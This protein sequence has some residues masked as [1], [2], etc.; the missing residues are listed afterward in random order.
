MLTLILYV[1]VEISTPELARFVRM[2]RDAGYRF[3][4]L[5]VQESATTAAIYFRRIYDE[6]ETPPAKG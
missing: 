2:F 6:C 4:D 1:P 5:T 3:D